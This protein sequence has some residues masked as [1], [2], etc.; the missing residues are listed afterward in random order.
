M[1]NINE[2]RNTVVTI[3]NGSDNMNMIVALALI[4]LGDSIREACGD[5]GP[6]IKQAGEGTAVNIGGIQ[7]GLNDLAAEIVAMNGG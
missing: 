2:V 1:S 4:Y 3:A 5:I 7:Q 6:A